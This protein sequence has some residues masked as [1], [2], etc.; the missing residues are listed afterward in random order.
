MASLT[1]LALALGGC[2]SDSS[3]TDT[4]PVAAGATGTTTVPTT[5]SAG[6]AGSPAPRRQEGGSE[7]T[8]E[9]EG[10]GS[11]S[12]GKEAAGGNEYQPDTSLQTFGQE[13]HGPL[14]AQVSRAVLSFFRAL[15]RPSYPAICARIA[16]ANHRQIQE[17]AELQRV[18]ANG[19]PEVL[20]MLMSPPNGAISRSPRSKITR[21]RVNGDEAIVFFRPPGGSVSYIPMVREGGR[22]R[23][24]T[25]VPGTPVNLEFGQQ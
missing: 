1:C 12:A 23:S 8:P 25:L 13:V 11:K 7:Q 3:S 5:P 19:C 9:G 18:P 14:K 10:E 22:W 16:A 21:V 6:E 15:A 20:E 24:V 2:G 17:Y 4:A